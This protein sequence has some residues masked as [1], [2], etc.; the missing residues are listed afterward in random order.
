MD[1]TPSEKIPAFQIGNV[2]IDP[3]LLSAP[4]AGFTDY[5]FRSLVRQFGGVGLLATEMVSARSVFHIAR[6]HEDRVQ[7]GRLWGIEDEPRPLAVQIWDNDPAMMAEVGSK[8]A[9]DMKASIIDINFG[10][11]VRRVS[12]KAESGS[13]LLRNPDK[14]QAIVERVV[15]ACSPTPVTAKIRL[16]TSRNHI[17]ACEIAAAVEAAGAAALTVHGRTAKD[18]F[19]GNADWDEIAKVK[20]ALKK[21][22]LIGNGDIDSP[23]KVVDA[24]AQYNVDGIMIGRAALGRPWLFSRAAA[25]LAGEPVPPEPTLLQQREVILR[26]FQLVIERFGERKGVL[27]MR[28][29]ACQY[30]P[31]QRGSRAFRHH[32]A[33]ITTLDDFYQAVD[34]FFPIE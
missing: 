4:M 22:P 28:R 6:R 26:H 13:Y 32:A 12:E 9:R 30:I 16:G 15:Q 14:L 25:A 20:E 33:S 34:N 31:G 23:E 5:P 27:L 17:N 19:L 7:P 3:P 10:C 29:Y 18:F 24:F 1:T 21:I 2:T 8:I 11:P